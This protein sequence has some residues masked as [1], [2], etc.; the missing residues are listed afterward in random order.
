MGLLILFFGLELVLLVLLEGLFREE[1]DDELVDGGSDTVVFFLIEFLSAEVFQ[2]LGEVGLLRS[3]PFA[4]SF[5]DGVGDF[6]FVDADVVLVGQVEVFGEGTREF[7]HKG[8][9]GADAE[10]AVVVDDVV[11]QE[12]GVFFQ[13]RSFELE[14]FEEVGFHA[15][16]WRGGVAVDDV[17]E[18]A[19][20]FGF[21]LVGGQIGE[22]D[23]QDL[24]VIGRRFGTFEAEFQVLFDDGVGFSRP[25]GGL[26]HLEG[27]SFWVHRRWF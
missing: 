24:A 1:F 20:D 3:D 7:L 14:V 19:D 4:D 22:G 13:L 6:V 11:E 25:G 21:H 12:E 8:V 17:V 9:D 23:G 26:E 27:I 5:G 10:A 2:H 16:G 18:L 15:L